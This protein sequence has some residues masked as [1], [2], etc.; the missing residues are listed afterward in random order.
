MFSNG[1]ERTFARAFFR[2]SADRSAFR[3]AAVLAAT[4]GVTSG[5][6]GLEG[7]SRSK[8]GEDDSLRLDDFNFC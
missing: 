4:L 5:R 3:A 6:I 1:T 8:K 2:R 7:E